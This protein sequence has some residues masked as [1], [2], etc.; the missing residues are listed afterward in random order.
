MQELELWHMI[1]LVNRFMRF[2]LSGLSINPHG[3]KQSELEPTL[4]LLVVPPS[5][6]L[7]LPSKTTLFEFYNL[8]RKMPQYLAAI[9][10]QMFAVYVDRISPDCV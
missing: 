10:E 1:T 3:M 7:I 4:A 8:H 9:F 6:P 2:S 5:N